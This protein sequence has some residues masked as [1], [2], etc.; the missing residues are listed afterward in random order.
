[1]PP[2]NQYFNQPVSAPP[3]P[4]MQQ[5]PPQKKEHN[6][7]IIVLIALLGLLL[8][9]ALGFG[10][11]A[12]SSRQD[13]K[14]NS[15]QKATA[16]VKKAN[17]EQKKTLEASF[18]EREKSP[19]KSY[20][21]AVQYASVKIVYSKMWSSY[22][23]EQTAGSGI[24]INGYMYPDFVPDIGTNDK[25]NYYLRFQVIDTQY[26]AEIS[27]YASNI[28]SGKVTSTPFVPSQVQGALVGVRLDG[29]IE[30]KKAGSMVILPLRDKTIKIWTEN[31]SA[32]SDFN[33]V[34][35]KNLTYTP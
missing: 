32:L 25:T 2:N 27:R 29:L 13:Y 19:Y 3:N 20:M 31:Q 17:V 16:A 26:N 5:L 30:S 23:I 4:M 18:E 7:A 33:N 12:F 28:K 8:I 11:W 9:S 22:F 21:T 24:L 35:L 15:D 34:I 14:N 6:W 1:M 10:Y